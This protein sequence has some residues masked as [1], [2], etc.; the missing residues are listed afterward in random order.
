MSAPSESR[1]ISNRLALLRT[2]SQLRKPGKG[3]QGR[4]IS[5]KHQALLVSRKEMAAQGVPHA[6][7]L[8]D[9]SDVG[10]CDREWRQRAMAGEFWPSHPSSL[11]PK[12]APSRTRKFEVMQCAEIRSRASSRLLQPRARVVGRQPGS[13]QS[14]LRGPTQ[15]AEK[16]NW[17][18]FKFPE[19]KPSSSAVTFKSS[20]RQ[21]ENHRRTTHTALPVLLWTNLGSRPI[22]F[23]FFFLSFSSFFPPVFFSN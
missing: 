17:L 19:S 4:G 10:H 20:E 8:V 21:A 16:S 15:G 7:W 1:H 23:S 12:G 9:W 5:R 14:P 22:T 18:V 13:T 11:G 3:R 2:D 6:G